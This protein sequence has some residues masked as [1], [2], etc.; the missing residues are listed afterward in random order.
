MPTETVKVPVPPLLEPA[1]E[2]RG[3]R[4]PEELVRDGKWHPTDTMD[5]DPGEGNGRYCV[6]VDEPLVVL[7]TNWKDGLPC[8]AWR[9]QGN[10]HARKIPPGSRIFCGEVPRRPI[11]AGGPGSSRAKSGPAARPDPPLGP[12]RPIR[13]GIVPGAP[14]RA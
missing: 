1:F 4:P 10:G 3:L 11:D 12:R 13:G 2:A 7:F 9:G 5:D 8:E 6:P 14:S